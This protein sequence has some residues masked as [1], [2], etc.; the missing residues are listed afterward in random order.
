MGKFG[1]LP[2]E[3]LCCASN[4]GDG[5]SIICPAVRESITGEYTYRGVLQNCAAVYL[6]E[7]TGVCLEGFTEVYL[8][9]YTYKSIQEYT[10]QG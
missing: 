4:F 3:V 7:Y 5:S 9:E 8:Q 1:N 6:Q 10:C 2:P